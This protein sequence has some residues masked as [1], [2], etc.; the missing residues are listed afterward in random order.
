MLR[1]RRD[2]EGE[3]VV[4]RHVVR[5][6]AAVHVGDLRGDHGH[7]A[8]RAARQVGRR[9]EDEAAGRRLPTIANVCAL[10]AGHSMLNELV[11]ALT[12]SLKLTVMFVF[13]A[14]PVAPLAGIVVVVTV[15]AWSIVKENTKFAAMC[16]ADRRRPGRSPARRRR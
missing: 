1:H 2:A 11:V 3:D 15:G 10:P 8:D 7:R 6:I 14:T 12:V 13:A 16:R 4:R 9:V 5:R